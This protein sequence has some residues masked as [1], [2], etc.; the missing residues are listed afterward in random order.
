MLTD[1]LIVR[2]VAAELDRALRGA[3][4]RDAGR[5]ADGRFGLRVP[6]GTVAIDAFGPTP[7][8]AL[9]GP[10]ELERTAGWIRAA[11]ATL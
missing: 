9:E 7:I 2:R 5:L 6:Q 4:I 10:Y 1:W 3:R 8:V 11:A